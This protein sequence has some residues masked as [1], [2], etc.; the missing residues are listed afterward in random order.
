MRESIGAA[1]IM[2]IT[3]TFITLFSG[4]LAFSINYSKAFRVK[5]GIV[6]RIRK[7]NGLREETLTDIGGFLNQIGYKSKGDCVAYLEKEYPNNSNVKVLGVNDSTPD[8]STAKNKLYNYCIIKVTSPKSGTNKTKS[9][10]YKIVVFYALKIGIINIGSTF[11]VTG[12]T[13]QI[14]YV[15]D[16]YEGKYYPR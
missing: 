4:F 14:S 2:V 8:F 15:T 9:T 1:W 10:Y 3:M 11:R 7:H 16:E 13:P 6:E 5:D 12:E